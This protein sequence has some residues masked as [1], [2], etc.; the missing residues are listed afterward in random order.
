VQFDEAL[1]ING[2][3]AGKTSQFDSLFGSCVAAFFDPV[4]PVAAGETRCPQRS[5]ATPMRDG[6][7]AISQIGTEQADKRAAVGGIITADQ[8]MIAN[9]LALVPRHHHESGRER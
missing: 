1:P 4:R 8:R 6:G 2:H 5:A 3:G 9:V 7:M